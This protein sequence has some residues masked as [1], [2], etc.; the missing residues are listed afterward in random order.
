VGG[1][2]IARTQKERREAKRGLLF[3]LMESIGRQ[4]IDYF[5]F[6]VM[7]CRTFGRV[8]EWAPN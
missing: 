8:I 3:W 1:A 5:E 7:S 2:P 6:G 4:P